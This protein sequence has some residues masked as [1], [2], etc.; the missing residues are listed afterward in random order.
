M[1]ILQRP[2]SFGGY[3]CSS[4]DSKPAA[5]QLSG[6]LLQSLCI[7]FRRPLA[8]V[9]RCLRR[10]VG[11]ICSNVVPK[12]RRYQE[13]KSSWLALTAV[14]KGEDCCKLFLNRTLA[15]LGCQIT[16]VSSTATYILPGQRNF[17]TRTSLEDARNAG[18]GL[19]YEP[20]S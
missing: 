14:V 12:A 5:M 3:L 8:D 1:L 13:N 7:N 9:S 10:I 18:P 17:H 4:V 2:T 19:H 15:I 11:R 6:E 16:S 20:Y